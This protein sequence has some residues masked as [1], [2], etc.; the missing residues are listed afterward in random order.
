MSLFLFFVRHTFDVLQKDTQK[1][2]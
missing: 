2:W 1:M